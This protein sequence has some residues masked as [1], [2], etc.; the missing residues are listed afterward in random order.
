MTIRKIQEFTGTK[1]T[2]KVYFD[3]NY[4]EFLV[5]F[6]YPEPVGYIHECDYFTDD[7][8]DA[9]QTAKQEAGL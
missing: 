7:K 2:A 6:H 9:I 5:R 3:S 8:E 1:C 4:G